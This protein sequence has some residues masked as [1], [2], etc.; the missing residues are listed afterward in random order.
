M[1]VQAIG[2]MGRDI[3]LRCPYAV[4]ARNNLAKYAGARAVPPAERGRDR[5][6]R[7]PYLGCA[8]TSVFAPTERFSYDQ[9]QL[10]QA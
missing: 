3:A 2:F 8:W 4:Q 1:R 7:G 10:S 6:A 5:A 9:Q